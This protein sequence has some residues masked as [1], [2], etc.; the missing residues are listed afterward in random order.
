MNCGFSRLP[1]TQPQHPSRSPLLL[2][3]WAPPRSLQKSALGESHASQ[4]P[5]PGLP[6]SAVVAESGMAVSAARM[7]FGKQSHTQQR[8]YKNSACLEEF[9]IQM[10]AWATRASAASARV[11]RVITVCK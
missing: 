5:A 2:K 1:C 11:R 4:S 3:E 7:S 6:E 9:R 10:E 8:Q